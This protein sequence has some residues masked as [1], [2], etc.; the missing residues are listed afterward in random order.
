MDFVTIVIIAFGLAMDA[1]AVSIGIG[2]GMKCFK[3]KPAFKVALF[4]GFFQAVMPYLGWIT[5]SSFNQ[6]IAAYDHWVAFFLL[7][8]IGGKMIYESFIIKDAESKFDS[9]NIITIFLLAI[10]TSIDALAVGISFSI[11][12]L[13]ILAPIIIIGI[14]TFVLSLIGVYIGGHFGSIFENKIELLGGI[15]LIGIGTKILLEHLLTI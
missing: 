5:G 15:I 8:I 14:I 6:Y 11:L 7:L 12:D 9:N 13:Q 4:F 1:F 3:V 10:A 2:V